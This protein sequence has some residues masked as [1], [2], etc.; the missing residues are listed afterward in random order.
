[1]RVCAGRPG[2]HSRVLA[3]LLLCLFSASHATKSASSFTPAQQFLHVG[4][5]LTVR[6]TQL[7][8]ADVVM[9]EL[10]GTDDPA[11]G[12]STH[13]PQ[14][15]GGIEPRNFVEVSSD[16]MF[17]YLTL[18]PSATVPN[19][20]LCIQL[21]PS[22]SWS[23]I[24]TGTFSFH[25]P[26]ITATTTSFGEAANAYDPLSFTITGNGLV[27]GILRLAFKASG[28]PCGG[29]SPTSDLTGGDAVG[30]NHANADGTTGSFGFTLHLSTTL[31]GTLRMYMSSNGGAYVDVPSL[32]GFTV[33]ARAVTT[34]TPDNIQMRPSS[35]YSFTV[36]GTNFAASGSS[37]LS[38]KA[39]GGPCSG[40]SA[41]DLI[42]GDAV[43]ATFV[44]STSSTVTFKIG[45]IF[46][47]VSEI[48]IFSAG[49][50]FQYFQLA[51][52]PHHLQ[53]QIC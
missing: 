43:A 51:Q 24:G 7:S 6:G 32:S 16:G 5:T 18:T 8:T 50:G 48:S 22:Q 15:A 9:L 33:L 34:F 17:A 3:A 38:F 29:T 36:T 30:L 42:G 44:S 13:P 20:V 4:V 40:S 52:V 19:A 53:N 10:A 26:T 47:S 21:F 27:C 46:E 12:N 2:F 11:Y 41:S 49:T 14:P 39:M 25:R 23:Q 35:P 1:M 31:T 45:A 28:L 37:T